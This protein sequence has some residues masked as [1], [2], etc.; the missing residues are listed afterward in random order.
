MNTETPLYATIPAD[1]FGWTV[2]YSTSNN[3]SLNHTGYGRLSDGTIWDELPVGLPII[4]HSYNSALVAMNLSDKYSPDT[5]EYLET[6]LPLVPQHGGIVTTK[7]NRNNI[8]DT[9]NV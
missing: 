8:K 2:T 9:N 1:G 6:L 3:D 7:T 5:E 4:Q